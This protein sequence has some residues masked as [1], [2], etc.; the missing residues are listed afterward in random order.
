MHDF[1]VSKKMFTVIMQNFQMH[2]PT[3]LMYGSTLRNTASKSTSETKIEMR[4]L[5][6]PYVTQPSKTHSKCLVFNVW[7]KMKTNSV[8]LSS[9]LS[10]ENKGTKKK[11]SYLHLWAQGAPPP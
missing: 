5:L 10:T 9:T 4:T 11:S 6:I 7:D 3:H 8:G 1:V 2:D